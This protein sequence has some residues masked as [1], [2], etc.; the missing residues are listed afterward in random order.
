[1]NWQTSYLAWCI[2]SISVYIDRISPYPK[3]REAG[4]TSINL[5]LRHTAIARERERRMEEGRIDGISGTCE[6]LN[7]ANEIKGSAKEV[8]TTGIACY[9]VSLIIL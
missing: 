6:D 5:K 9:T 4:L 2:R 3:R 7:I 8:R 1:M